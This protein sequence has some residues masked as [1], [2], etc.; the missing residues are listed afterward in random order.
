MSYDNVVKLTTELVN[1]TML[2]RV[3]WRFNLRLVY[4]AVITGYR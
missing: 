3:R 2:E 4:F 1:L